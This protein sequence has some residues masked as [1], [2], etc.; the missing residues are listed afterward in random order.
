MS[1][2]VP[3]A[4]I[5][6]VMCFKTVYLYGVSGTG[7]TSKL[8]Q[9]KNELHPDEHITICPTHKACNLVDGCTIHRM[10]GISTIGSSDEYE[11][12]Q[13][14]KNAGIKYICIDEV[15]MVSERI[16]CILC[17]F[18]ERVHF[19]IYWVWGPYAIKSSE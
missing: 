13:D 2:G 4:K 1:S 18:E 17:Q 5:T 9:L 3:L 8:L 11:K 10:F 16:W 12:A 6:L 7:K 19:H 14:L 15:S